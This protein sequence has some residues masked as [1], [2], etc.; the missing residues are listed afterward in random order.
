LNE[1]DQAMYCFRK[2]VQFDPNDA[3]SY[4]ELAQIY[5]DREL[6]ELAEDALA[7]LVKLNPLH[8]RAIKELSK[9]YLKRKRADLGA[10]LFE[11]VMQEDLTHPLVLNENNHEDEEVLGQVSFG[12]T[13]HPQRMGYEELNIVCEL[14]LELEEYQK[15]LDILQLG[16]NRLQGHINE[17][18][19]VTQFE[20]PIELHSKFAVCYYALQQDNKARL[21]L[22]KLLNA[23]P[24]HGDLSVYSEQF[25]EISEVLIKNAR[26]Q[27]VISILT[28]L[29]ETD[30]A[31]RPFVWIQLAECYA[32]LQEYQ[33][34]V[35]MYENGTRNSCSVGA[36]SYKPRYSK[37]HDLDIRRIR[38]R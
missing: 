7:D 11:R 31:D 37:F 3:D 15:A 29:L 9:L 6:F 21:H 34:S 2:A 36:G 27:D 1:I 5:L 4:W 19:D 12:H 16:I 17:L 32:E 20:F 18:Y 35:A 8:I 38:A 28:K 30:E 22:E 10:V 33:N 25:Y 13:V 23:K 14:Y 26:Y 24:D